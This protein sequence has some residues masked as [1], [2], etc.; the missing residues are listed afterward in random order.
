MSRWWTKKERAEGS[1][2]ARGYHPKIGTQKL[3]VEICLFAG[4][5]LRKSC[6]STRVSPRGSAQGDQAVRFIKVNLNT[7]VEKVQK[8]FFF[9][10]LLFCTGL[11]VQI[12]V[13]RYSLET[14]P[15]PSIFIFINGFHVNAAAKMWDHQSSFRG[16]DT[17]QWA[18][19]I[20]ESIHS[21]IFYN[22]KQNTWTHKKKC[23]ND[24]SIASIAKTIKIARDF[25]GGLRFSLR[26][27]ASQWNK[28]ML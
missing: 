16:T 14:Y 23:W 28:V 8:K 1:S 3:E 17:V 10:V 19:S 5:F 13:L 27:S 9:A 12:G 2:R 4:A 20:Y 11:F 25:F 18:S 7:L 22:Y 24:T 6:V 26:L 15:L 21:D